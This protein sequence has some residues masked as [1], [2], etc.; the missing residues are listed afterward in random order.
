MY[1]VNDRFD[2]R[3]ENLIANT[4]FLRYKEIELA[5]IQE[6]GRTILGVLFIRDW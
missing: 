2:I 4:K 6:L 3:P 1:W 5:T